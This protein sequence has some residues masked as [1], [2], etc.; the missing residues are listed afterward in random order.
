MF[1]K[2]D[3]NNLVPAKWRLHQYVDDSQQEPSAYPVFFK[4]EWG[5]N[6]A[7]V[8]RV[9]N[10]RKL[11]H[12]RQFMQ[13]GIP[14]LLQE[15]ATGSQEIEIFVV[16]VEGT[17]PNPSILLVTQVTN[18]SGDLL[19]VN[20]IFNRHTHYCDISRR[21]TTA[22]RQILWQHVQQLGDFAIARVGVR[23]HSIDALI[24][25]DFKVV[26]INLFVPMPLSLLCPHLSRVAKVRM[27]C[28][29]VWALAKATKRRTWS[30]KKSIFFRKW[31]LSHRNRRL[32]GA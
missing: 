26:E 6:S 23:C 21:L 3:L 10:P 9:D 25:G 17:E 27:L 7:G 15:A 16:N 19:P 5:Q 32:G 14:Y 22:Q 1:S 24:A 30:P 12:A 29:T 2:Q 4:P 8:I 28:A 20:G 13:P 18:D 11:A 31:S